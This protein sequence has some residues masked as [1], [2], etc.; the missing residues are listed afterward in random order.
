MQVQ[1]KT[2]IVIL[3]AQTDL[4]LTSRTVSLKINKLPTFSEINQG[5]QCLKIVFLQSDEVKFNFTLY[6]EP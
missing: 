4:G 1:R 6:S 2:D 5:W 3:A